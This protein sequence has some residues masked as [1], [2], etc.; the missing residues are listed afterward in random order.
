MIRFWL[1]AVCANPGAAVNVNELLVLCDFDPLVHLEFPAGVAPRRILA[2]ND[3]KG[4]GRATV[5]D[6]NVSRVHVVGIRRPRAPA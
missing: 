3:A 6:H 4:I 2:Y 1:L 5:F